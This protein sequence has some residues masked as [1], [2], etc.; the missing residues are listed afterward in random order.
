MAINKNFVIKNGLEVDENLIFANPDLNTVGINTNNPQHT[1]DVIGGIGASTLTI[2]DGLVLEG[3]L[4]V[5]ETVGEVGAYLISTGDG[6]AWQSLPNSRQIY[7]QIASAGAITFSGFTY[8][9]GL[10]DVYINGVKLKGDG[11]SPEH[12]FTATTGNTIILDDPCFGGETVEFVVYSSYSVAG[13]PDIV[14]NVFTTGIVT[15]LGGFISAGNTTP[16]Q[17]T[18]SGN[19]LTFTAVGI[20]S[21]TFTLS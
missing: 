4:N 18:L 13:T 9:P 5:G 10:L 15:S 17:I 8:V 11:T 1:F 19:L 6:V 14:E 20:G 2:R 16:I 3:T 12:E 21:T 7:T